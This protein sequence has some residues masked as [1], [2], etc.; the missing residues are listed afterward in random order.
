[1]G[2]TYFLGGQIGFGGNLKVKL[3]VAAPS[4]GKIHYTLDGS[5]PTPQSPVYTQPVNYK[6]SF[7]LNAAYF[8]GDRQFGCVTRS[9]YD[10]S[11]I[12][13]FIPDWQLS[14]PYRMEGKDGAALFDV[15]FDPEK[16]AGAKWYVWKPG[17]NAMIVNFNEMGIGGVGV[18]Y[19]RTQIYSPKTQQA[20][21]F[22]GSDDGVKAWLN[23]KLV[24]AKNVGR[25]VDA[26]DRVEVTLNE[27]W[28]KLVLK[29]NNTGGGW[30]AKAR[31]RA[32][33]GAV[34]EGMKTK[35]E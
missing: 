5:E 13:G 17:S 26:E 14:G 1:M 6:Q 9:R 23:G 2:I 15:Q 12:D 11:D 31:V 33:N 16:G 32:A 21:L 24:D 28:N 10:Y 35:A 27:G 30:A 4:G 3:S 8:F 18:M 29:V 7:V 19:L 34:L 22:V 25:T 20:I